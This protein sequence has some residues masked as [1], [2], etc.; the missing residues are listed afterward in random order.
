[1]VQIDS[2]NLECGH[3][4]TAADGGHDD[5]KCWVRWD[6]RGRRQATE[7]DSAKGIGLQVFELLVYM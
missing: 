5:G 1:M 3:D 4:H 6:G 2:L 7:R